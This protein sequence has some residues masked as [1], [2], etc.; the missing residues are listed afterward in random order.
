MH[1]T[2]RV[3]RLWTEIKLANRTGS[4][5]LGGRCDGWGPAA[6]LGGRKRNRWA[7]RDSATRGSL[8]LWVS[9]RSEAASSRT[10]LRYAKRKRSNTQQNPLSALNKR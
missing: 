5:Q 4:L 2:Q 10:T 8:G 1:R 9:P 6:A 3:Q 7:N